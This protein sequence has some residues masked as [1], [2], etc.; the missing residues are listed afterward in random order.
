MKPTTL[1]TVFSEI[2]EAIKTRVHGE[3]EIHYRIFKIGVQITTVVPKFGVQ[4]R[5]CYT[6][7]TI[8][9]KVLNSPTG[10]THPLAMAVVDMCRQT[11]E[12]LGKVR[13]E[14]W[15][16]SIDI[17]REA[18]PDWDPLPESAKVLWRSSDFSRDRAVGITRAVLES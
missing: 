16:N 11:K 9:W 2:H 1:E 4:G 7:G 3:A 6:S 10:E 14:D 12:G 5:D 8:A 15:V 18:F 17:G 13:Y